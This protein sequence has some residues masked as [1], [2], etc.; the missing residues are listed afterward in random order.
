MFKIFR[1]TYGDVVP[2][3]YNSCLFVF[4]KNLKHYKKRLQQKMLLFTS[5]CLQMIIEKVILRIS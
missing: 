5:S 2:S 4:S 1:E 3:K